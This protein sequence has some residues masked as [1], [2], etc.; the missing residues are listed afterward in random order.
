[1][2]TLVL[3]SIPTVDTTPR[4]FT[5]DLLDG[6]YALLTL[7]SDRECAVTEY[8]N[9][10]PVIYRGL[11]GTPQ[12]AL[13]VLRVE[14]AA[15]ILKTAS[16]PRGPE[17]PAIGSHTR[18]PLAEEQAAVDRLVKSLRNVSPGH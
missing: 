16:Q 3:R 6:S 10:G 14:V 15:R 7:E 5:V 11:F 8:R 1:M 12:D 17:S 2:V 13:E 9:G 18:I 4:Q